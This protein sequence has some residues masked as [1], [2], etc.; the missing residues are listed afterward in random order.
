MRSCLFSICVAF[1]SL[2]CSFSLGEAGA[3]VTHP[4]THRD[5]A[6]SPRRRCRPCLRALLLAGTAR[7]ERRGGEQ[8]HSALPCP[9]PPPEQRCAP[10]GSRGPAASPGSCAPAP[11][12]L[13]DPPAPCRFPASSLPLPCRFPAPSPGQAARGPAH[14]PL[15]KGMNTVYPDNSK[16]AA[17]H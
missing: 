11:G 15:A 3:G 9:E 17:D 6:P 13:G 14:V 12:L 2:G 5:A 7:W 8:L 4:G 1:Y 16:P 10:A